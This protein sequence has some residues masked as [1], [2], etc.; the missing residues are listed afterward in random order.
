MYQRNG[1]CSEIKWHHKYGTERSNSCHLNLGRPEIIT[2]PAGRKNKNERPGVPS[3]P[4][5]SHA[6][7]FMVDGGPGRP[8]ALF[9][10]PTGRFVNISGDLIKPPLARTRAKLS[11]CCHFNSRPTTVSY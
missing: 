3:E 10:W 4:N 11:W 2:H 5:H 9:Y 7:R 8:P 1:R 6:K